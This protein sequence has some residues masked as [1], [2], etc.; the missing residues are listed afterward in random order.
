MKPF[1]FQGHGV[2]VGKDMMSPINEFL[3]VSRC[4]EWQVT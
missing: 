1:R 3:D 2:G 4:T